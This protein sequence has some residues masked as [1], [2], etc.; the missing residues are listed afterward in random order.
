[1]TRSS[2]MAYE[3][4]AFYEDAMPQTG[5]TA[6]FR[7]F[8]TIHGTHLFTQNASEKASILATRPD[9]VSEGIA[10]LRAELVQ[11]VPS[12]PSKHCHCVAES[13]KFVAEVLFGVTYNG[14]TLS[15]GELRN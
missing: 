13:V 9:L 15:P 3:G 6:V 4:I 12:S 14:H 5:D 2:E 11:K 10:F 7:F 8:D 1:M